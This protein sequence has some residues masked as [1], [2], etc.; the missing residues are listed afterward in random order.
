MLQHVALET[1]EDDVEAAIAFWALLGFEQVAVPEGQAG[2]THWVQRG[3]TQIHLL[4][5]D[6]PVVPPQGH[7]AVVAEDFDATVAA[8][9]AAGHAVEQRRQ[10][11]GVP[12]AF[13]RSPGGHMV[14]LM[15]APPPG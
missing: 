4:H 5:A 9:E 2:R 14:E 13:A 8:L 1:R 10:H 7:A 12:R 3:D 15:A 6:D 11:W